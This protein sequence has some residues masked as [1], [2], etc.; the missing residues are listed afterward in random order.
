LRELARSENVTV[1]GTAASGLARDL[2]ESIALTV[3]HS[4]LQ[5]ELDRLKGPPYAG[6]GAV[7]Y[8]IGL[9]AKRGDKSSVKVLDAAAEHKH[10][11][12]REAALKATAEI[13]AREKG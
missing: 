12:V 3:L 5:Q 1:A 10:P 13:K 7:V 6:T 4:Y 9:I 11:N 8:L 2:D